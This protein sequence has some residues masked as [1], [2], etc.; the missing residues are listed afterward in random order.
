MC[1]LT[2]VLRR[3]ILG[4]AG[5][6]KCGSIQRALIFYG[7]NDVGSADLG[8]RCLGRWVTAG[9]NGLRFNRTRDVGRSTGWHGAECERAADHE[10]ERVPCDLAVQHAPS[11]AA[12]H[13]T[14]RVAVALDQGAASR[15]CG[16]LLSAER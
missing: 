15:R 6:A 8:D 16:W 9:G 4:R 7:G 5:G 12:T 3:L 10:P 1:H 11:E 14:N 13:Q 2:R